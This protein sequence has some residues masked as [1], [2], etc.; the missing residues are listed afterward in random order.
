MWVDPKL[1]EIITL[2]C[3]PYVVVSIGPD[4]IYTDSDPIK[5]G[6]MVDKRFHKK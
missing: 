2:Q 1:R 5:P 6:A 3:F 4:G